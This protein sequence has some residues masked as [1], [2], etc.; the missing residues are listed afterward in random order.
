[1]RASPSRW[2]VLVPNMAVAAVLTVASAAEAA[3]D[4]A[5][6]RL[7]VSQMTPSEQQELLRKQE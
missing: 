6:R 3:D 1:M 2:H 5:S 7:Q 4:M